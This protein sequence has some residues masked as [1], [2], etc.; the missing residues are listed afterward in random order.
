MEDEANFDIHGVSMSFGAACNAFLSLTNGIEHMPERD[1]AGLHRSASPGAGGFSLLHNRVTTAKKDITAG[2][3]VYVNYGENW[4]HTRENAFGL[5]PLK[6]DHQRS[7]VV[8]VK[9]RAV[10]DRHDLDDKMQQA[11]LDAVRNYAYPSRVINALPANLTDAIEAGKMG[12]LQYQERRLRHSVEWLKENGKCM[13]NLV[14]GIST[15][16]DAG[17]GAFA[18]RFIPK[19]G[20]VA[21]A[22]LIHI[23]DRKYMEI[24]EH[25]YKHAQSRNLTNPVKSHQLLLNYCFGHKDSTILLSPY[26][27]GTGYINHDSKRANAKIVWADPATSNLQLEWLNMDV[28]ALEAFN[29]AGLTFDYIAIKDIQEGEE[30]FID[31]GKEWEEAWNNHIENWTPVNGAESYVAAHTMNGDMTTPLRTIEEQETD[32]YPSNM[33]IKC[34]DVFRKG[35]LGKTLHVM[36]KNPSLLPLLLE[37]S[38]LYRCDLLEKTE[39]DGLML[40][41]A[42]ITEIPDDDDEDLFKMHKR[43]IQTGEPETSLIQGRNV[44]YPMLLMKAPRIAFKFVDRPYTSD[45]HLKNSFRHEMMIPDE[46]FPDAWRNKLHKP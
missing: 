28:D 14:E 4:F 6:H 31:Y 36:R 44:T 3:E 7:N 9:L 20:L 41:T 16:P 22:P 12:A 39:Q 8:L 18:T 32:P 25:P 11:T 15:I 35:K 43:R 40:Y 5:V 24:L 45:F 17:R 26:G 34:Y 2:A 10:F 21:P 23:P 37:D 46:M 29:Y 1:D 42:V 33:Q 19:G 13:D 38:E 30:V 27:A